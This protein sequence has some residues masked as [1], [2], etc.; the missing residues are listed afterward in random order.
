MWGTFIIKSI[1]IL[2]HKV[3]ECITS[4]EVKIHHVNIFGSNYLYY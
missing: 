2:N 1:L 4:K 3:K